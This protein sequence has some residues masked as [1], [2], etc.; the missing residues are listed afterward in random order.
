MAR[1]IWITS[2]SVYWPGKLL[3]L[4]SLVALRLGED[5]DSDD[6]SDGYIGSDEIRAL[7]NA[8]CFSNLRQLILNG[9]YPFN[10]EAL[11]SLLE[12]DRVGQLEVLEFYSTQVREE[13]LRELSRCSKLANLRRLV[14]SSG[15]YIEPA[16]FA[17][18]LDSPYLSGL[19][20]LRISEGELLPE[21]LTTR[22]VTRFGS[23]SLDDMCD[24]PPVCIEDRIRSRYRLMDGS[25][26]GYF[27]RPSNRDDK[28][29]IRH[30]EYAIL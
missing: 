22:L 12:W 3:H 10:D 20:E 1:G 24:P 8:P 15:Y 14:V 13:G 19:R 4:Q 25:G 17:H 18:L 9:H 5:D 28:G 16:A 26:F 7:T 6:D 11:R 2:A 21:A 30:A 23:I 27:G 29:H